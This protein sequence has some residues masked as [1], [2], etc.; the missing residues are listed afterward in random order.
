MKR[1]FIVLLGLG[2]SVFAFCADE[3]V[4]EYRGKIEGIKQYPFAND[5][6]MCAQISKHADGYKLRLVDELNKRCNDE[7][8]LTGLKAE[9]GKI[10]LK[11]VGAWKFT[12]E[13][14][15]QNMEF[16]IKVNKDEGTIKLQKFERKSP[17]LG[18]AVPANAVVLF[19]GTNTDKWVNAKDKTPCVWRIED[20]AMVVTKLKGEDAKKNQTIESLDAFGDFKLH[21]EFK[22]PDM[23]RES[24]QN[25][26]NSGVFIGPYEI[27]ILD[28]FG[29]EGLWNDC[30]AVY[31][32]SPPQVNASLPP[33]VWQTYDIIFTAAKFEG[34]KLIAFPKVTV[35]LNGVRIQN[36]TEILHGTSLK[37]TDRAKYKHPKPPYKLQLQDHGNPLEFRNIWILAI[38]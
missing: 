31:R 8:L 20:G 5:K 37:Q 22:T 4:G 15:P 17:S 29:N 1:F 7:L 28:S 25:R 6:E 35:F 26:A 10:V 32:I 38:K 36:E 23:W 12:G 11:D 3:F 34:D 18:E 33:E 19:D 13:I 27:Q 30:G 16:R 24:G 9:G 14:T 2:V 21:L